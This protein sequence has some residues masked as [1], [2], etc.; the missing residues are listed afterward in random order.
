MSDTPTE[1]IP[2]PATGRSCD[3][4]VLAGYLAVALALLWPLPLKPATHMIGD[5]FGDPLLNAWI[6]GWDAERLRHGLQGLWDAPL[7]YPAPD[8]LAWSE[9]LL[10]IA[11]FVAPAYWVTGNIV[12]VY[13][14]ALVGSIVLAGLGMYLLARDLTGRRDAAWLAGLL[15]ACLPYRI[16][17][18]SHLQVLMAGW[19]PLA[20][21][22]LHRYFKTGSR[23]ALAGFVAAYVL[24]ALSNGYYL[25]FLA[26][27][28][29][30]V[31]L[32]HLAKRTH[33]GGG[34]LRTVGHLA[35]AACAIGVALAPVIGAYLRVRDT[36]GFHRTRDEMI[37]YSATPA[38]YGSVSSSL[39]V[40][41]GR[42]PA[43]TAEAE[44]FPGLT[45][46]LLAALGL[47]A[48]G[49]HT[50]VRT[51]A[52][53]VLA[54]FV[55]TMGPR[56]DFGFWQWPSGPYDWLLR[57]PGWNGLRVPARFAMVGYLGLSVLAAFGLVEISK[58][59]RPR[60]Y[61]GLL[62]LTSFTAVAE[63]LPVLR[64]E[65]FPTS[66]MRDEWAAYEWLRSQPP[67]PMLEFP[68]GGT[69]EGTRYLVGTLIHRNR[70]VNGYSGHDW[71]LEDLFDGP[72]SVELQYAGELL[73]AARAV[74]LRY[75][76]VHRLLYSDQAFA[77]NLE[78]T[79]GENREQVAEV[80]HF[81]AT[82]VIV[83]RPA[84]AKRSSEQ[85]GDPPLSLAGCARQASPNDNAVSRAVDGNIS[86][87]WLTVRPQAGD[88]W[89]VVRCPDTRVLT[90]IELLVDQRSF[91][92]YP[93]RLAIDV[94]ADGVSF[95]PHWE[96]GVVAEL[97]VS[98]ARNDRPTTIRIGIPPV[99][100][101]A[102]RLRQTGQTPRLWFWS[103]DELQLR[104]R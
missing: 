33:P 52:A 36:Q 7:F 100:F 24:T 35:L 42:L 16:A 23:R 44:L 38:A 69:M 70:I 89:F 61:L 59:L 78:Y 54:V 83:L 13:N 26:V 22:G 87:R 41:R 12:L 21:L 81:G 11:V 56:P 75:L 63:G 47:A 79:L 85:L 32:W 73:R 99:A 65:R 57:L 104:G 19:M 67:G 45:L 95:N 82:A 37:H 14:L 102:V 58:W 46:A 66:G 84:V 48:G 10:G 28:V 94:S 55:L 93:R 98:V 40:W 15:F 103:I 64:A 68:V 76:L 25:F 31:A 72:V 53:V 74:G 18:F 96:G 29:V 49:R 91:A 2:Q 8:T 88:E 39:R 90:S 51:Y 1:K 62:V 77:A 27:P 50:D 101:R 3:W 34:F 17:Q 9:H 4:L 60:V 97:A 43:G 80:R 5:A 86:T 20:L 71:K 92:N 6:L 30:I